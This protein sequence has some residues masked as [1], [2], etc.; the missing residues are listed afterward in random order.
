MPLQ[1]KGQTKTEE[2]HSADVNT[3]LYH[4]NKLYSGAD[5]GKIIV[6]LVFQNFIK[7]LF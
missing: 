1:I 4:N 6:R 7:F 2:Q 3:L 5:D